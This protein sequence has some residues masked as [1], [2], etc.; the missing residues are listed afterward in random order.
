MCIRD[1]THDKGEDNEDVHRLAWNAFM[2]A[3]TEAKRMGL[4]AAGQDLLK[5][6]FSGNV[7]GMGPGAAEMTFTERPSEPLVFFMADK[8]SPAAFTKPLIQTF[9]NPFVTPGLVIDPRLHEGFKFQI[10][11]VIDHEEILL[12]A[13]E[14]LHYILALVGDTTRYAIK[15]IYS[16]NEE[17]GIAAVVSTERLNIIAGKYVGKDDPVCIVR[18]QSG[19]PAVGEVLQPYMEPI[20]VA[21]WMRGSHTGVF[22]P[23]SIE[24][25]DPT[26]FDGPPPICAIGLHIK[27]GKLQGLEDP[28]ESTPG[29]HI[30]IDYFK[31][32]CWDHIR[33]EAIHLNTVL[34]RQSPIM[35]AIL[36]AEE[37]EYTTRPQVLEKL[38]DRFK[39]LEPAA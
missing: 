4:Y 28:E 27:D 14:E 1:R 19:F 31:F 36:P 11:D 20:F 37:L 38:K 16:K 32:S 22:Y 30:P 9:A 17:L 26:Y 18:T 7:K 2:A 3:A 33:R 25:S 21:G 12:S 24:E 29:E 23:T 34:R 15:R 6:A 13:P 10:V 35:P 8:T 5:D 39:K